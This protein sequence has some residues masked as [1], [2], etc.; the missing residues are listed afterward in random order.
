M[1]LFT[2]FSRALH[3]RQFLLH[4]LKEKKPFR[5]GLLFFFFWSLVFSVLM[6]IAAGILWIQPTMR[7][8]SDFLE[9]RA[10]ETFWLEEHKL[11]T[12]PEEPLAFR[13]DTF[14]LTIDTQR[15]EELWDQR[16]A[17]PLSFFFH[18]DAITISSWYFVNDVD[19]P[20][21]QLHFWE[22]G[23]RQGLTTLENPVHALLYSLFIL[24]FAVEN[25]IVLPL[26]LTL[27]AA[28]FFHGIAQIRTRDRQPFWPFLGAGFF[29][30][31]LVGLLTPLFTFYLHV[32]PFWWGLVC[33][34][35]FYWIN[36]SELP[37][38]EI[39]ER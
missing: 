6:T 15:S 17:K 32:D 23:D 30:A 2:N 16:H 21:E 3:D 14:A 33:F 5:K 20:F 26:V 37:K 1:S 29:F 19:L 27:I 24:F 4:F 25:F 39:E 28:L 8:V 9:T 38:K 10:S 12:D 18:G 7:S 36:I 13:T 35:V 22:E 31:P 34:G 11:H